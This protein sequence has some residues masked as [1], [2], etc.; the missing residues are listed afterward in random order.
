MNVIPAVSREKRPIVYWKEFQTKPVPQEIHDQWTNQGLFD[1]GIA[2]ILGRVW[3]RNDRP[4]YNLA[5]I[6]ADNKKAIDELLTRNGKVASIE[7]FSRVT[8][9]EQHKDNPDRLHFYVYTVGGQL[10]NKT[11]DTGRFDPKTDIDSIPAF[12]V[13]A[14]SGMLSFPCPNIHKNGCKIEILG[15]T[16]PVVLGGDTIADMQ[17]HLDSICRRFNLGIS[18]GQD[19]I[20]ISE[21]FADD[22][23]IYES[24]NRHEALLRVMESLI[25]R[26]GEIF[27]ANKIE[28][29]S[30]DWNSKHCSPPL[31][32]REFNK[33]WKA[34][35]DFISRADAKAASD[36]N[37][38]TVELSDDDDDEPAP[39]DDY[40]DMLI[41]EYHFKTLKDTD[42][43]WFYDREK[44]IFVP[45]GEPVIK[46]RLEADFGRS[47]PEDPK[48]PIS[49][50][51]VKEHIGHIQ[52]RTY[53]DRDAFNPNIAW[54]ACNNYMVNLATREIQPFDPKFMSTTKIPVNYTHPASVYADFFNMIDDEELKN[55]PRIMKFFYEIMDCRDVN[56]LLDYLAYSLWR[57]YKYN[58]WMLLVGKG[59]NGKS[60]LLDL[61]ER[62]FGKENK[63][64]ETLDRLLN[65]RF[66][67]ANLFNKMVNVDADVS[68]DVIFK[69]T[70]ILKKLT[71]NDLHAAEHKFKRPFYF[72]N[73]AK[74]YFSCNKIPETDDDTDAFFRRI[75]IINFTQQFFGEKDD[76]HLIDKISTD[77]QLSKLLGEL[78]ARVP[79][80]IKDGLRPVT[81]EALEETYD[82]Y[83]MSMDPVRS[84]YEHAL[85]PEAGSNILKAEMYE[86]YT[87]FCHDYRL[88][89]ES[90]QSFSRKLTMDYHL[91]SKLKKVKGESYP[92]YFWLDVKLVVWQDIERKA[93]MNLEE[94]ADLSVQQRGALK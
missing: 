8:I 35:I 70:G 81:N 30:R 38:S 28:Q 13:K 6:D 47:N 14:S 92:R 15:T 82:K 17:N 94:I 4:D 90:S 22:T 9:V 37:G 29:L 1:N 84:F 21:L 54:I 76:P 87:K 85:Q 93:Q 52:R 49:N 2:I 67:I 42:E 79:R 64:G 43:I 88:T 44:G 68:A 63:S 11:S 53:I 61:I 16:E 55:L 89:P 46:A 5:C 66:S 86:H 23:V 69:N 65:E 48:P 60:I 62:F 24:H 33:Q 50:N 51:D 59:F 58:F 20:P 41:N 10:R 25:R 57:D 80:I 71:G 78:L 74:L 26:N 73:H 40:D 19:R 72:R 39:M 34:A 31:N 27:S 3:H 18:D 75:F 32:E 45:K 77:E 83:M 91:K 12:E 7:Q 56:L 36:D